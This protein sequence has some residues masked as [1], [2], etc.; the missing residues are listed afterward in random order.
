MPNIW[1]K[2]A[3]VKGFDCGSISFNKAVN[4]FEKMEISDSIYKGVVEPSYKNVPGHMPT[5]LVTEGILEKNQTFQRIT[6]QW[7]RGLS[8]AENIYVDFLLGK[9][10]TVSFTSPDILLMNV[11]SWDTLVLSK[12]NIS[13]LST[14]VIILYQGKQIK[15]KKGNNTIVNNVVGTILLWN[16]KINCCKV[17]TRM[18]GL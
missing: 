10:K 5:V 18:F 14:M 17:S 16:T 8:S 11:R 9:L 2:Q 7:V 3:Y 6:P 15:W 1:Y 13:L 12:L 4:M